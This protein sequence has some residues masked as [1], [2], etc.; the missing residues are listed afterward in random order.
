MKN[1]NK[2]RMRVTTEMLT[3]YIKNW[4][5]S[6]EFKGCSSIL[7]LCGLTDYRSEV[8]NFSYTHP[9]CATMKDSDINE[10]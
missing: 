8:P 6:A 3:W 4:A 2:N 7:A 1:E 5:D 10:N 9:L